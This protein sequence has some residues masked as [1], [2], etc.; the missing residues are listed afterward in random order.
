M[1]ANLRQELR[2][3]RGETLTLST[4]GWACPACTVVNVGEACRVCKAVHP[5]DSNVGLEQ[6]KIVSGG[7]GKC[8]RANLQ[9]TRCKGLTSKV[10]GGSCSLQINPFDAILAGRQGNEWV[11]DKVRL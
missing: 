9:C 6:V 1:M 5:K 4:A 3:D 10:P 7:C 2:E 8:N 11:G